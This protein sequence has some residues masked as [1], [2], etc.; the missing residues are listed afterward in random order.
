MAHLRKIIGRKVPLRGQVVSMII[1]PRGVHSSND[2]A[3]L[4]AFGAIA[5]CYPWPHKK[6]I[7]TDLSPTTIQF[8][9]PKLSQIY[10]NPITA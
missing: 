9:T 8:L 4:L 7:T 6:Y 10:I 2:E 5:L 1:S 3:I